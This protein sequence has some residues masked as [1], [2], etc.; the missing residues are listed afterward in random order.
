MAE[1]VVV[2]VIVAGQVHVELGLQDLEW[3]D[4]G[5]IHVHA[6]AP[7]PHIHAIPSTVIIIDKQIATS[8]PATDVAVA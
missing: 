2:V 3:V 8:Y 5:L 6:H 1:W 4:L 7:S